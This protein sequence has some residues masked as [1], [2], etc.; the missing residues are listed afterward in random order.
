MILV[1]KRHYKWHSRVPNRGG[2]HC[3]GSFLC[4]GEVLLLAF[5]CIF[6]GCYQT[7]QNYVIKVSSMTIVT[8]VGMWDWIPDVTEIMLHW[9]DKSIHWGKIRRSKKA[10]YKAEMLEGFVSSAALFFICLFLR[11][12]I[13]VVFSTAVSADDT[14]RYLFWISCLDTERFSI[15]SNFILLK[16][17]R[18]TSFSFFCT[19]VLIT[20]AQNHWLFLY[21]H[22]SLCSSVATSTLFW[23]VSRSRE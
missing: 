10:I 11:K 13:C 22:I 4:I 14:H 16:P 21:I 2:P 7:S 17:T 18:L 19:V 20:E 5:S 6:L 9:K 12:S 1:S 3:P 8:V 15:T 23:T